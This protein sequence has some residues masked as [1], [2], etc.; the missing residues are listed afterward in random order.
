MPSILRKNSNFKELS[1]SSVDV[2][3]LPAGC[4]LV[5][6]RGVSGYS[7]EYGHIEITTGDGRAVS[8]GITKHLRNN[9][10]AVFMPIE[11]NYL[12]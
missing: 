2:K 11:H 12:A 9:P 5:Y 8:D 7:K 1:P 4:I 6:G 3:K 10:T